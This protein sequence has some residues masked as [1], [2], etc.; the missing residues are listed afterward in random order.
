MLLAVL[1]HAPAGL[2]QDR[3]SAPARVAIVQEMLIRRELEFVGSVSAL[4]VSSLSP[5]TAGFVSH[6]L[7]DAGDR[8][9]RGDVL[10]KLD[11]E[12][13][14]F[15]LASDASSARRAQQAAADA[16]RRLAEARELAETQAERVLGGD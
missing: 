4:R 12:L 8:V 7:V 11:D 6:L 14:R 3:R 5:A 10:L 1:I 2:A 15:Q 16:R 13:A 9:E